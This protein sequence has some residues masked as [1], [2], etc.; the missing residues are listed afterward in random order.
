MP[1]A[2]GSSLHQPP[3]PTPSAPSSTPA[4]SPPRVK[5]ERVVALPAPTLQGQVVRDDNTPVAGTQLVFVNA[6][7]QGQQQAITADAAGKFDVTLASGGWLIY[8]RG[9]DD[10]PAFHSKI[11]VRDNETRQVTLVS[12]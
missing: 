8:V 11:D 5:L 2:S 4:G 12:R 7:A 6:G 1:P 10:R 9:A 3:V